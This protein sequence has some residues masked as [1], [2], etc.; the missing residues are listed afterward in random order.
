M[1]E[2]IIG[3]KYGTYNTLCDQNSKY[4]LRFKGSTEEVPIGSHNIT[5]TRDIWFNKEN[6]SDH[7]TG[8]KTLDKSNS[9]SPHNEATLE[10][11]YGSDSENLTILEHTGRKSLDG[12]DIIF[13]KI[14]GEKT[15]AEDH[16]ENGVVD[17]GKIKPYNTIA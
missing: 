14:Y 2:P 3:M 5:V 1:A 13:N 9:S 11:L 16:N 6:F 4:Y 8:T 7:V 17:E 10:V 15:Y 12:D